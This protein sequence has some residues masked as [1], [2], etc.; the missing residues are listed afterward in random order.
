M[1][2]S[3]KASYIASLTAGVVGGIYFALNEILIFRGGFSLLFAGLFGFLSYGL[4]GLLFAE[5]LLIPLKPLFRRFSLSIS[6]IAF[7]TMGIL[8]PLI[9]QHGLNQFHVHGIDP[10]SLEERWD[11][12]SR[13]I[14]TCSIGAASSYGAWFTLK[15]ELKISG[16]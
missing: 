12:I 10:Y 4:L 1:N 8:V 11:T 5:I 2:K 3:T 6:G 15:R 16:N 7:L 14:T 9:L 13:M